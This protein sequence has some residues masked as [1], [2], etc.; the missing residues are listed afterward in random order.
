[1]IRCVLV[2]TDGS[3]AAEAAVHTGVELVLSLGPEASLHV[4]SAVNYATGVPSMLAKAP[5]GAPDLLAEQAQE[6]L[7]LAAAAAFAR[8]VQVRTHLLEGDV[9]T[10]VLTCAQ[11][12]GAHILIA[13]ASGRSRLARLVMGST[14]GDLVR[15]STLPV[16][17][18]KA[19]ASGSE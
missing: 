8:G 1:M 15:A 2:A 5:E 11:D 17:V 13:G 9:V 16:V 10:A 4:A 14:V 19:P 18:V 6:A 3:D 12:V 7:Q